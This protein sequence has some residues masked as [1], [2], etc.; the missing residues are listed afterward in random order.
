MKFLTWSLALAKVSGI[1]A[2]TSEVEGEDVV[3]EHGGV[4][5][6]RRLLFKALRASRRD[7]TLYLV[8][9]DGV[10][11]VRRRPFKF[12]KHLCIELV[13]Y[14]WSP[15]ICMLIAE[16]STL[17]RELLPELINKIVFLRCR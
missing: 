14:G 7:R 2:K 5:S 11:V 10:V 15:Y 8:R 13:W 1:S 3:E 9:Q 17:V 16:W 12:G 4:D 6:S